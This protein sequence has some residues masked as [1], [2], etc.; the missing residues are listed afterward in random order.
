MTTL[1]QIRAEIE[2]IKPYDLPC[3]KRTPEHIK[4]MALDIIDK[5]AEQ[6]P[7][8]DAVSREAVLGELKDMYNAAKRWCQDA[9]EDDI[10]VRADAVMATLIEQKL[11]VEA[12]SSVIPKK[13][14]CEDAVSRQ[15]VLNILVPYKLAESKIAE[16]V[17]SLPSVTPKSETVTEFADRCRECGAKYGKLLKQEPNTGHWIDHQE[18]RWIYAKCS[19][20]GTVHDTRTNYCPNCG[21]RMS[22][23]SV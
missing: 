14:E 9:T 8:E 7:C 2:Q 11:R 1:E 22:D 20:C 10:K 12:L 23:E 18:D 4:D 19:E 15:A 17:K 13:Q 5:Y 21:A 16:E 6:E 3:D